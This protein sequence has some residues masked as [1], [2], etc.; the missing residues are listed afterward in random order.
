MR[1]TLVAKEP[2]NFQKLK[3]ALPTVDKVELG[4]RAGIERGL[5]TAMGDA[6]IVL[7]PRKKKSTIQTEPPGLDT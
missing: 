3:D 1:R 2:T 7:K 4:G 5:P 6:K